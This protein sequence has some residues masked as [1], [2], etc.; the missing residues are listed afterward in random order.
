MRKF[1]HERG[2]LGHYIWT[3]QKSMESRIFGGRI[4]FWLRGTGTGCFINGNKN[5]LTKSISRYFQ[6]ACGA[7]HAALG[8]DQAGSIRI[9]ASSCGIVGLKPTHGLVPYTG[10][11]STDVSLDHTGPITRTVTDCARILHAV[12]GFDNGKDSRQPSCGFQSP[13]F[14]AEVQKKLFSNFYG[15]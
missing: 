1:V 2:Q 12:A 4:Q 8:T 15:F 7:V 11:I 10:I 3:R 5:F 13:N 14:L 9:P 6:V